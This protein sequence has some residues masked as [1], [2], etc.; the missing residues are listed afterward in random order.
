MRLLKYVGGDINT[1]REIVMKKKLVLFSVLAVLTAGS[2]F[3]QE[4]YIKPTF[5]AGF[6]V[7]S[8]G[9]NSETLTTLSFDVDFVT[10][11]GLTF[12]LQNDGAWNDNQTT[13]LTAFG[14]GYTYNADKWS[15]GGKLMHVPFESYGGGMGLDVNGTWW[16]KEYLGLTGIMDFYFG[17]GNVE[18]KIFSMRV[19]I[20]ARF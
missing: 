8:G 1:V 10:S 20:S 5:G 12:G 9:G 6:S 11:L 16:F 7:F 13:S 15:A 14:L 18:W 3:T 4:S 2:I 17:L 19:G